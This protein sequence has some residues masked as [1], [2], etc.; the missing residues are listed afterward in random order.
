MAAHRAGL[1]TS[2]SA[3]AGAGE[4]GDAAAPPTASATLHQSMERLVDAAVELVEAGKV[5]DAV[6]VLEQGIQ[7]LNQAFPGA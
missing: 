3:A 7:V 2:T 5:L 4:D 6:R 1:S